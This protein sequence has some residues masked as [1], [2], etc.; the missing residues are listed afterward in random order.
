MWERICTWF[1]NVVS[2]YSLNSSCQLVCFHLLGQF[3][4]CLRSVVQMKWQP[5]QLCVLVFC[6]SPKTSALKCYGFFSVYY[7]QKKQAKRQQQLTRWF[8]EYSHQNIKSVSRIVIW[9]LSSLK[10]TNQNHEV[11]SLQGERKNAP[12]SKISII[13]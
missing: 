13:P 4:W 9:L 3:V 2:L 5:K 1:I 8:W 11:Y 10:Y 7:L 12:R 6:E